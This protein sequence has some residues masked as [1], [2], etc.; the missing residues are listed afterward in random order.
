MST[1]EILFIIR[2]LSAAVLI[3]FLSAIFVVMW[4]SYRTIALQSEARRRS[5]GRLVHLLDLDGMYTE[6]GDAYPLQP[7][8]SIGRSPTN[9]VVLDTNFAS[10]EHAMIFLRD[11]Q[12][13]LEDR[14]S[15]NGTLLNGDRINAPTIITDGD[16]I[17]VG[18]SNFKL[19]LE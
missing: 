18:E 4:R 15:R 6:T 8:T 14:N 2:L 19:V 1:D 5:Y 9:A 13:W 7:L 16:I 10:S 3:I 17:G 11:G 12:W